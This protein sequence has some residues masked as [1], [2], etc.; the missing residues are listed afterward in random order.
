MGGPA[1]CQTSSLSSL[2]RTQPG[3]AVRTLLNLSKSMLEFEILKFLNPGISYRTLFW[4]RSLTILKLLNF[5]TLNL[6]DLWIFWIFENLDQKSQI[7]HTNRTGSP[8]F[9]TRRAAVLTQR[10]FREM[11]FEIE[12]PARD[13]GI[14]R[15]ILL[16]TIFSHLWS[17]WWFTA[18]NSWAG[19]SLKH[20]LDG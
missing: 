3:V 20:N 2:S 14:S 12:F 4:V 17:P 6:Q 5:K 11:F 15:N 19:P 9:M 16:L 18:L 13:P 1:A 7:S 8:D 10:N